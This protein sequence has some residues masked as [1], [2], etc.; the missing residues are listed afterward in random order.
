VIHHDFNIPYIKDEIKRF[1][2]RYADRIK[3]HF[4]IRLISE[5]N[6]RNIQTISEKQQDMQIKKKTPSR[7]MHLSGL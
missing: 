3:K 7:R 5:K 1:S 6:K 4:N 2:Q